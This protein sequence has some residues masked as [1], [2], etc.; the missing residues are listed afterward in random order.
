[1][2]GPALQS[3]IAMLNAD[4]IYTPASLY[5]L[6]DVIRQGR[7]LVLWIGAG[8]S[9]WA[10]L[11]SWHDSAT[12]M[13]KVFTKSVPNF[14][15]D[16]AKSHIASKAYPDFFQLC[17]E[18]DCSLYNGILLEQFSLPNIGQIYEQFIECLKQLAP[19]QIVTTNVDLCLE[20]RLGTIDVIER[21][22]LERC[23]NSLTSGTPFVAKLHGSVSSIASTVFA[24]SDYQQIMGSEEYLAAVRSIFSMS[25][26]AFLGYGVQD[27]Y[28]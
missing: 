6:R 27:E 7:P 17:K 11:P 15:D 14:P 16:L 18:A 20:Q 3:L 9:R 28:V 5:R 1:M 12:K 19:L 13:R 23:G 24:K 8:A 22:D 4:D 10:G 26:V 25:S 2:P 21:T